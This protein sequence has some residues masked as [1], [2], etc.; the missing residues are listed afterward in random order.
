[1]AKDPTP[2]APVNLFDLS[3]RVAVITGGGGLL[4]QQH[5]AAIAAF[6]GVPV[7]VDIQLDRPELQPDRLAARFGPAARAFRADITQPDSVRRLLAD[8][9]RQYNGVDILINNAANNP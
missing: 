3:G 6:G 7:L 2:A 1:M 5:A 4:G 8:V 9:L